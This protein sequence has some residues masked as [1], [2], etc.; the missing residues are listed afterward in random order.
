[1]NAFRYL[2]IGLCALGMHAVDVAAAPV[3]YVATGALDYVQDQNGFVELFGEQRVYPDDIGPGTP[4]TVSLTLDGNLASLAGVADFDLGGVYQGH[5]NVT[6]TAQVC[7]DVDEHHVCGSL[8]DGSPWLPE[9][10]WLEAVHIFGESSTAPTNLPVSDLNGGEWLFSFSFKMA[11][12]TPAPSADTP[13][14][15]LPIESMAL[16]LWSA[17]SE[18]R[19]GPCPEWAWGWGCSEGQSAYFVVSQGWSI[20]GTATTLTAVPVPAAAWLFGSGALGLAGAGLRKAR[21]A[22]R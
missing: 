17:H 5:M 21:A 15:A 1:M 11:P 7:G 4:F 6:A 16:W 9:S 10:Q 22:R 18:T 8:G 20:D 19:L 14:M 3:R 12:N 13:L 2:S